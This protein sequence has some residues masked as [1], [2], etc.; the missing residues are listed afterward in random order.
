MEF[1][2]RKLLRMLEK[3]GWKVVRVSGSHHVLKKKGVN[4]PIVFQH[5]KKDLPIGLVRRIYKDAG[6]KL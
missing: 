4:H 1:N 6:W 2:S 5:P 3:D